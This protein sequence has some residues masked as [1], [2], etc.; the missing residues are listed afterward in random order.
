MALEPTVIV[1]HSTTQYQF[2]GLTCLPNMG[3]PNWGRSWVNHE[4]YTS[5]AHVN[6]LSHQE[7]NVMCKVARI[8]SAPVDQ[9][10]GL[11]VPFVVYR[12]WV[13]SVTCMNLMHYSAT[14]STML[15][16]GVNGEHRFKYIFRL[17]ITNYLVA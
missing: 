16:I 13:R 8:G 4:W 6:P 15:R 2:G 5:A 3:L 10:R 7:L 1:P 17:C 14:P 9:T 11:T 12:S